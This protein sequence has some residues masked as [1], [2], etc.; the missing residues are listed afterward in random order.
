MKKLLSVVLI[1]SMIISTLGFSFAESSNN[2]Q[3][4]LSRN[5]S[6]ISKEL[7]S[8][9]VQLNDGSFFIQ[10][11]RPETLNKIN[12]ENA[13]AK[14]NGTISPLSTGVIQYGYV[15]KTH[16][17]P[18][19]SG[20]SCTVQ[21]TSYVKAVFEYSVY[22]FLECQSVNWTAYGSSFYSVNPT[23]GNY[24]ISGAGRYLNVAGA[25]NVETSI[26]ISAGPSF[27]AAGWSVG[28]SVGGNVI[29]RKWVIK[30]FTFDGNYPGAILN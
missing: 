22:R 29:V 19:P 1:F 26:S 10:D 20:H 4:S 5:I 6:T 8:Q 14:L 21:S 27:G 7:K 3:S 16:S 30:E 17:V 15:I 12:K 9:P 28:A 13:A 11:N 24:N 23:N 2:I 18:T 25:F